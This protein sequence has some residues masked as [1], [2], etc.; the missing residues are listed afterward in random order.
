MRTMTQS[1]LEAT[2]L[3]QPGAIHRDT[4]IKFQ[5]PECRAEGHDTHRDNARLARDGT[6]G[7]AVAPKGSPLGSAHWRAIRDA[8]VAAA[9]T[10]G[11][12]PATAKAGHEQTRTT[13]ETNPWDAAQTISEYLAGS[14]QGGDFIDPERRLLCRGLV[15]ETFSPRGI[16]KSIIM[17]AFVD[18]FIRAGVRVLLQPRQSEERCH[19]AAARLR[20]D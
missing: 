13:D 15:T 20:D 12:S 3:R 14:D 11:S 9:T 8:L 10:N 7:C 19:E 16:G 4:G 17:L 2:A 18:R 1:E 5:C 6:W